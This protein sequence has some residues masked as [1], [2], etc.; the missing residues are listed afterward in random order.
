MI[1]ATC[2]GCSLPVLSLRGQFTLLDSFYLEPG[3]P[4][5][6]TC[7]EW[8][9]KCLTAS[10]HGPSWH[11]ARIRNFL[12]A[13]SYEKVAETE[14]WSVLRDARTKESVAFSREGDL[15][16]LVFSKRK[17][18]AVLGGNIY[19][20]EEK[21]HNLEL[22]DPE[23]V[24]IVQ[25]GLVEEKSFPLL[26]LCELLHIAERLNHPEALEGGVLHFSRGLQ[27]YWSA[28]YIS[29]PWEYGV[30]VPEELKKY[31]IRK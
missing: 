20:I 19:N 17:T 11:T 12:E 6:E 1:V 25:K 18:R 29:A 26:T 5:P 15:L 27:R 9:T 14:N 7:G 4:D 24:R 2:V 31:V 10:P 23:I 28:T 3:G 22:A 8:H 30:F 13:R 21:E 16:S